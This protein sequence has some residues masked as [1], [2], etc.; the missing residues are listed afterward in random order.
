MAII[1]EEEKKMT[2]Y[3]GWIGWFVVLIVLAAI[4][5]YLVLAAPPVPSSVTPPAGFR[6][7]SPIAQL[8]FD[9]AS[10]IASPIFQSLKQSIAAPT[11]SGPAAIGRQNPFVSP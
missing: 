3:T 8:K 4:G 9:P 7:I 11:S 5:Y 1:I 10:V 2:T 6:D